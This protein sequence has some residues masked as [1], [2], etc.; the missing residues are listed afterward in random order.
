MPASNSPLAANRDGAKAAARGQFDIYDFARVLER[1]SD[2]EPAPLCWLGGRDADQGPSF[3]P[4]CAE[5][6]VLSGQAEFVD[7]GWSSGEDHCVHCEDCGRE[8]DYN[9]TAEGVSQEVCNFAHRRLRAPLNK[10]AAFHIAR[11]LFAAPNDPD[12]KRLAVR[13]QNALAKSAAL[14]RAGSAQ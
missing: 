5:K 3:C 1:Y 6:R 8:L 9:L 2:I 4:D 14:S 12:V 7:G 10:H 11:V 13:A